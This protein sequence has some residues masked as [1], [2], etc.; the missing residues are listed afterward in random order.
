M[1]PSV[2]D[3]REIIGALPIDASEEDIQGALGGI[4]GKLRLHLE[5][6]DEDLDPMGVMKRIGK[7][8]KG[9]TFGPSSTEKADE[10]RAEV[11]ETALKYAKPP[12][13]DEEEL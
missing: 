8:L 9:G 6:E 1:R 10:L 12:L 4:F 3:I 5:N 7:L 2:K 11:M 13:H